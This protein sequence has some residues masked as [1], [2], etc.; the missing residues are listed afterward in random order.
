MDIHVLNRVWSPGNK[1]EEGMEVHGDT[2]CY[3]TDSRLLP[4][5]D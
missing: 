3:V 4:H 5:A 1:Q 2:E